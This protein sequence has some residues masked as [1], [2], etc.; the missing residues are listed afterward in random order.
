[1]RH[2]HEQRHTDYSVCHS[3]QNRYDA[4]WRSVKGC[5]IVAL[6]ELGWYVPSKYTHLNTLLTY[7]LPMKGW[8]PDFLTTNSVMDIG[9]HVT[10]SAFY[11]V[12][13]EYILEYHVVYIIMGTIYYFSNIFLINFYDILMYKVRNAAHII[14]INCVSTS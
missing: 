9:N 4:E 8:D 5:I 7:S 13:V 6:L 3:L 1:M 14:A 11:F 12:F 2:K 10:I